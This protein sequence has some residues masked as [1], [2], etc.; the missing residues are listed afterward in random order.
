V[1]LAGGSVH[2]CCA[3]RQPAEAPVPFFV[4][5]RLQGFIFAHIK[6]L[7]GTIMVARCAL[8]QDCQQRNTRRSWLK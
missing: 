7:D 4:W 8:E 5:R 6:V 2:A 3:C 1:V